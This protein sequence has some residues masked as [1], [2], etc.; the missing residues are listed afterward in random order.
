MRKWLLRFQEKHGSRNFVYTTDL[1]RDRIFVQV[2]RERLADGCWYDDTP[3]G[4]PDLFRPNAHLSDAER[5]GLMLLKH[6]D[7]SQRKPNRNGVIAPTEAYAASIRKWMAGRRDQEYEG[8]VEEEI[9]ELE[10][11]D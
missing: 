11:G 5:I 1:E 10:Q 7:A 8:Y 6:D 9:E 2:A 4:E 3:K